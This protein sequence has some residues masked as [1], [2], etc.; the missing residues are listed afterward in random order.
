MTNQP[1]KTFPLLGQAY[2]K[3]GQLL[4]GEKATLTHSFNGQDVLCG[5]VKAESVCED[6]AL[7]GQDEPPTCPVCRRRDGRFMPKVASK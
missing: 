4:K 6:Y 2:G 5:S 3:R 7:P 1:Y